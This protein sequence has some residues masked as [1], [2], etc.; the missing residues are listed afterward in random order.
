MDFDFLACHPLA[1][2]FTWVYLSIFLAYCQNGG[3]YVQG[4]NYG[5][6]YAFSGRPS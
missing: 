4:L 6:D 2:A 1:A 5:V 3:T